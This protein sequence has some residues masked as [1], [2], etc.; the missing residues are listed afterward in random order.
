LILALLMVAV[1]AWIDIVTGYEVSVFALYTFPVAYAGFKLGRSGGTGFAVLCTAVWLWADRD[2]PYSHD[3]IKWEKA[4]NPLI[5]LSFIAFSFDYF[6]RSRERDQQRLRD[7]ETILPICTVCHRIRNQDGKWVDF[8]T[9]LQ[10]HVQSAAGLPRGECPD[11][12]GAKY[13]TDTTL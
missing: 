7:L 1:V 13:V 9:H 10:A 6:R 5:I 2:H 3:W 4:V 8:E 11:C 12:T